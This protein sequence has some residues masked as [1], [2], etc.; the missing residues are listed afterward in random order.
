MAFC[1][2]GLSSELCLWC[3]RAVPDPLGPCR[4]DPA[5][6]SEPG[7]IHLHPDNDPAT[8]DG[9]IWVAASLHPEPEG[10][11]IERT[12]Q[13]RLLA[14]DTHGNHQPDEDRNLRHDNTHPTGIWSDNQTWWITDRNTRNIYIYYTPTNTT[15]TGD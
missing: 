11:A 8:D 7:G 3:A 10:P 6:G 5:D 4:I 12:R 14:F 2:R 1:R 13:G 15:P 9:R